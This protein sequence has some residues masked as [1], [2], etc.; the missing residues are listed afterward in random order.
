MP[1]AGKEKQCRDENGFKCH[2]MSEGHVRQMLVVGENAGKY[3]N[4]YSKNFKKD[5]LALLSRRWGTKRVLANMVYQEYIA[6]KNHSHMN[7]TQWVTLSEFVKQMGREGILHVDETEKGLHMAWIDSSPQAAHQA[8]EQ[9]ELDDEERMRKL[10][11]EQIEKAQQEQAGRTGPSQ[12]STLVVPDQ[13]RVLK[14]DQADGPPKLSFGTSIPSVIATNNAPDPTTIINPLKKTNPLK[15]ALTNPLKSKSSTSATTIMPARRLLGSTTADSASRVTFLGPIGTYSHQVTRKQFSGSEYTL[16]PCDTI[17]GAV[18]ALLPTTKQE[19]QRA[20][21]AVIPIENSYFGPVLESAQVLSEPLVKRHTQSVGLPIKFKIQHSLLAH[22]LTPTSTHRRFK[23]IYSH[24][25]AL[26]QCSK[27]IKTKYPGIE[28]I[29]TSSTS[30]AAS[31]VSQDTSLSSLAIC[32]ASCVDYFMD[33][34]VLD[35]DIQDAGTENVTTFIVLQ[36]H[37]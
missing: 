13:D 3:V 2:T 4:E 23:R 32:S 26:G 34:D 33:L 20:S 1:K 35:F 36:S 11:A 7:T 9:S 21:W 31:I 22:H 14:R 28:E 29:P 25:Q 19:H 10:I 16:I 12:S 17:H 15:Q 30:E 6:D 5:F 18:H 24:P 37:D 8:K 27:Y